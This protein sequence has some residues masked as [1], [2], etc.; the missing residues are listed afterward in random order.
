MENN[1]YFTILLKHIM[2]KENLTRKRISEITCVP[3]SS[4]SEYIL[5][6]HVPDEEK[7]IR[8]IT[9][10]GYDFK[11]GRKKTA[12]KVEKTKKEKKKNVY[13]N[14][15]GCYDPTAGDAINKVDKD[16]ERER[17]QKMLDAIF[18]ICDA[19]D[20]HI[21]DRIVLKDKRSGKIYR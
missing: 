6:K 12:K 21:E 15:S 9:A 1:T 10:L 5:G 2:E 8:I 3:R 14:A 16:L 20:F 11:T 4:I 7:M 13:R 17:L 18:S 19:A